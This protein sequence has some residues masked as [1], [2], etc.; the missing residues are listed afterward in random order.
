[1][2]YYCTPSDVQAR[3]PQFPM[4]ETS[5]PSLNDV[6]TMILDAEQE[7]NAQLLNLGYIVPIVQ[8]TSPLSWQ[9]VVA[10]AAYSAIWRILEARNAA[11]GGDATAQ[12]ALRAEKYVTDRL[13][14]LADPKHP[15]ELTD[16][17]RTAVAVVKP[18][19]VLQRIEWPDDREGENWPFSKR[20]TMSQVFGLLLM[21][22]P[23]V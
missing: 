6:P 16:C 5:K 3:M 17:P 18:A 8:T 4:T 21:V 22:L 13:G 15:F 9:V 1:M 10:M 19:E 23:W 12:S 20:T 11:V 14:W 7:L 2:S